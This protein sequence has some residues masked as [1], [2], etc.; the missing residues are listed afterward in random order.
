[1]P[2][3]KEQIREMIPLAV[4]GEL[5]DAERADFDAAL[6]KYPD[7]RQEMEEL[8]RFSSLVSRHTPEDVKEGLLHDART[9]L[10]SALRAERGR[11]PFSVRVKEWF[12]PLFD[13]S[14]AIAAIIVALIG[15]IIGRVTAPDHSSI[16]A[17]PAVKEVSI[18]EP[19]NES[20]RTLITNI[21]FIDSDA[22]DGEIEF[23]FNAVA[24]MHV[25]GKVDDPEIQ[26]LLTHA[27]LNESNAGV[28]LATLSAISERSAAQRSVDPAVRT[29]LIRSLKEDQNPG[30]RREALRV[31]EQYGFDA[32]VRDALIFVI[33]HDKNAGLRVAA[34]NALQAA[35]MDGKT[36]DE[37]SVNKLKE[38][39]SRE[40]NSYIRN[41]TVNLVKEIYQ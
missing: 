7:L 25:K 19:N 15:I 16:L 24:P 1:M 4:Y 30:V 8:E 29:T 5:S 21:R 35:K 18:K 22:S 38:Q 3:K 12:V 32:E 27:L 2:M 20:N 6:K 41:R 36:F 34:I 9:Q 11:V 40:Q 14:V 13:P 28:R 31:L 23:E 10:R 39:I 17:I 26:R 33:G 37:S